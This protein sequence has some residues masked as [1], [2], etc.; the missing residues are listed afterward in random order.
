MYVESSVECDYSVVQNSTSI[1]QLSHLSP[2]LLVPNYSNN[3]RTR[4]VGTYDDND[5]KVCVLGHL[6]E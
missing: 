3:S 2:L 6:Q 5:L 4:P 1:G